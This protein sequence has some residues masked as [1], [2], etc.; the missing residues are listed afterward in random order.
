MV[1]EK[2]V[3]LGPLLAGIAAVV[4]PFVP[5]ILESIIQDNSSGPNLIIEKLGYV[6][7]KSKISLLKIQN[8]GAEPATNLTILIESPINITKVT[9]KVGFSQIV[10]QKPNSFL[11]KNVATPVNERWLEVDI[12]TIMQGSGGVVEI[13]LE[14]ENPLRVNQ[15]RVSSV[16]DQG[17][18]VGKSSSELSGHI[19]VIIIVTEVTIGIFF[20]LYF[21]KRRKKYAVKRLLDNIVEIRKKL[22]DDPTTLSIFDY[23]WKYPIMSRAQSFWFPF[24]LLKKETKEKSETPKKGYIDDID[25]FLKRDALTTLMIS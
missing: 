9:Y 2:W 10:F 8:T 6:S 22:L 1:S 7:Y 18:V 25:D 3:Y 16:Y 23:T 17:S 24:N 19:D 4:T 13:Q 11:N 12:P 20:V 5:S 21:Y 14:F 15:Y